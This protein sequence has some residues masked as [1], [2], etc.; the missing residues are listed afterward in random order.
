M[1]I[2]R[3]FDLIEAHGWMRRL[4]VHD[5]GIAVNLGWGDPKKLRKVVEERRTH[6]PQVSG[7][8]KIPRKRGD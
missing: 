1:T 4:T 3:L 6:K 5:V 8:L 2:P 7:L